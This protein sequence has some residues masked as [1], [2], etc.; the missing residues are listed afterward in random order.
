MISGFRLPEGELYKAHLSA[1]EVKSS[2]KAE[3]VTDIRLPGMLEG[4]IVRAPVPHCRI[5]HLD[6]EKAEKMPGV[7]AIVTGKEVKAGCR[8]G[9][10]VLDQDILCSEV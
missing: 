4:Y 10:T 7:H 1:N 9:K 2:G 3:F 6:V 8:I 5:L